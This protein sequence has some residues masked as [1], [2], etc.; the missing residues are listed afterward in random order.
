MKIYVNKNEVSIEYEKDEKIN[1]GEYKAHKCD[2]NFSEEYEGL[3]KKAIF[4]TS[5][6]KKEMPIINNECDIP[7]EVLNSERINLRVYAYST[8][9]D[10]LILRYS[11]RYSEFCTLDGSYV[12]GAEPSEE[13]TPTQF[14]QYTDELNKGLNEVD[15]SLKTLSDTNVET[16]KNSDY[17]KKQGDYAH[18]Q[19]DGAKSI[20]DEIKNKLDNG[21]FNGRDGLDGRDGVDGKN[22]AINGLNSLNIVGGTN[23]VIEQEDDTL[24]INNTYT[25]DDSKIKAEISTNTSDISKNKAD[26]KDINDNLINYSLITETGSK[27]ELNINSSDFKMTAIL[28]NKN[29]DIVDTS[30]EIDLPLET[31]VIGASYDS[32][33]KELVIT[34]QNGTETRVPISSLIDGLVNEETLNEYVKNTDYANANKGGVIKTGYCFGVASNGIPTCGAISYSTYQNALDGIFIAKGTLNNVLNAKIGSIDTVLD[35]INGE[36]I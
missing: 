13:I 20:A 1:R 16:I 27:I 23:I 4:E 11:P 5:M 6:I 35:N 10:E 36:V 32:D 21:E 19:G 7:Y 29:G 8:E 18:E 31:M 28:K 34:L 22:A 26:I 25:Y 24:K 2:F 15:S 9:N 14:E 12:D 30:N 33:K 17:A 3:T